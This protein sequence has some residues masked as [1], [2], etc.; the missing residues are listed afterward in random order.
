MG[1][2]SYWSWTGRFLLSTPAGKH[3]VKFRV[4]RVPASS[5]KPHGLDYSLT[6]HDENGER[7]VGFDNAHAVS[8]GKGPAGKKKKSRDHRHRF[9][10][11]KPYEYKNAVKLLEDFWT[12]VETVLKERGIK[13]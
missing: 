10:S 12:E 3:W 1:W 11:V 2:I 8:A 7:L 4:T 9:R 13:T 5:E 6:L